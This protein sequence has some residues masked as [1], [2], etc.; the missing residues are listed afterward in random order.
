MKKSIFAIAMVFVFMFTV[1]SGVS[2]EN[3]VEKSEITSTDTSVPTIT[4]PALPIACNNCHTYFNDREQYNEHIASCNIHKECV[5]CRKTF[6]NSELYDAHLQNCIEEKSSH[7]TIKDLLELILDN[8]KSNNSQWDDIEATIIK[9]VDILSN[10]SGDPDN[11]EKLDAAVAEL[12][13]LGFEDSEWLISILK[14]KIKTLYAGEIAVIKIDIRTPS[15]TKI[16]Y[17]DTIL[18]HADVDSLPSYATI[19]WTADNDNFTIV[20]I[21]EDGRTCKITPNKSGDTVFT[22]SV[23]NKDN[24]GVHGKDTQTMTSNAGIFQKILAFFK[25]LF[26]FT[27]DMPEAIIF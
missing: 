22:A 17:G 10:L 11:L 6:Y 5:G 3:N 27:K 15:Q 12:E 23:I 25:N 19:Q 7:L 13:A 20:E 4:I 18:L 16:N 21:S 2:A 1:I 26:R 9:I 14:S 24:G 8:A